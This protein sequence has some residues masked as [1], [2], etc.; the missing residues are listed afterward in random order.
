EP[1]GAAETVEGEDEPD[2]LDLTPEPP[3]EEAAVIEDPASAI[4]GPLEK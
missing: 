1:E 3:A 2:L 4:Q